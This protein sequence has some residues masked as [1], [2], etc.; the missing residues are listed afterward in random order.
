MST[1]TKIVHSADSKSLWNYT[2]APGW[3]Q[4]EIEVFVAALKK[5]GVGSWTR[6]TRE[7]LLPGKTVAQ[8]YNQA[9][10]LVGQQSLAEFQGL[11]LHLERIFEAN[12]ELP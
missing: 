2:L 3:T 12:G 8:M 6:I 5:Y 11:C 9:Q 1:A 7:R 10:R 4:K